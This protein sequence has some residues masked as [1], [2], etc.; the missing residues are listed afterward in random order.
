MSP[1]RVAIQQVHRAYLR[2]KSHSGIEK[3]DEGYG[4]QGSLLPDLASCQ[5]PRRRVAEFVTPSWRAAPFTI[6]PLVGSQTGTLALFE[7]W[8]PCEDLLGFADL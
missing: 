5:I 8:R 2:L 4:L 3:L 6:L 1:S 7:S